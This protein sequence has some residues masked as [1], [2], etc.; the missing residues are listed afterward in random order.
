MRALA[1][2]VSALGVAALVF[3]ILFVVM[4][5]SARSEVLDGLK[6]EGWPMF[7]PSADYPYIGLTYEAA[8]AGDII[9][10]VEDIDQAADVL[11]EARYSIVEPP[12]GAAGFGLLFAPS[13][14]EANAVEPTVTVDTLK[15]H[16]YS[17]LIAFSSVINGAKSGLAMA[18]LMQYIGIV[19]IIVGVALMLGG[20]VLSRV[21][22]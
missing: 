3:G 9:D 7:G 14:I 15:L 17:A 19:T 6:D 22:R 8:T 12:A 13:T 1:I 11:D 20:L 10:T 21:G 5:N 18:S 2:V 4:S 16:E